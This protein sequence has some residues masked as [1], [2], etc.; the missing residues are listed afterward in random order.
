M[1]R[2]T[3]LVQA[4]ALLLSANT[5]AEQQDLE[6]DPVKVSPDLYEVQL[7]NEHVR[8]I[9]YSIPPGE[10]DNWH[11]HPAK[12][13]YVVSGGSLRITT[14]EGESFVV[15]EETGSSSWFGAVGKHFGENVG[16]TTVQ[17]VFTEIKGVKGRAEN[18]EKYKPAHE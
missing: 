17:I 2:L 5:M 9:E 3:A 12:V 7:E 14:A 11:T 6:I 15:Q 13:S 4:T 16:A 18:V 10:K 1:R 8:V